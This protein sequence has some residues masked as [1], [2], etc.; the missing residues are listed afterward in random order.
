MGQLK[1]TEI[2]ELL[3]LLEKISVPV[4]GNIILFSYK[5]DYHK[6][7]GYSEFKLN[8]IVGID[9]S[10]EI[11]KICLNI[12]KDE[13]GICPTCLEKSHYTCIS[14]WVSEKNS[15]PSCSKLLDIPNLLYNKITNPISLKISCFLCNKTINPLQQVCRCENCLT[16]YHKFEFL[17]YIKVKGKCLKCDQIIK[18]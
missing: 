13:T 4:M 5:E 16:I 18:F 15:C 3:L 17:E 11:C 10:N 8:D 6:D 14:K 9:E 1:I 2:D 7:K 12:L